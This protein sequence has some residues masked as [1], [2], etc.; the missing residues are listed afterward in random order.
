M[1]CS[2]APQSE[3]NN[4]C[5]VQWR[6]SLKVVDLAWTSPAEEHM[7][8]AIKTLT[9]LPTC[10]VTQL[11]LAGSNACRQVVCVCMKREINNKHGGGVGGQPS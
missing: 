8:A 9:D 3:G 11:N 1:H 10:A 4:V 2:V 7:Y 6:H 5:I